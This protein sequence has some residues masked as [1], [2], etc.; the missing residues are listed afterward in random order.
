MSEITALIERRLELSGVSVASS[1]LEQLSAYLQVLARWNARMNLTG[2]GNPLDA[3]DRLI[4][5]PVLA[6]SALDA[7]ARSLVDVGSGGGSP[8]IPLK[9]MRSDLALT[10][11]EARERKSVFLR[12]AARHLGLSGVQVVTA[13]FE[14][15]LGAE[16]SRGKFDVLSVR[17][18]RVGFEELAL[19]AG[20]LR[21]GGQQLWFLGQHEAGALPESLRIDRE[22]EL[23]SGLGSRLVVLR[24]MVAG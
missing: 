9:V 10:M 20:A 7:G 22:L 16:A 3:V 14:Q 18:V 12:E 5:E 2:A 11:I 8:A 23:V 19:F 4:V 6:A 24:R 21:P 17:A 1:Q 15:A 13:T